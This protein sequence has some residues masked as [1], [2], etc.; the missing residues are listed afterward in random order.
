M[1]RTKWDRYKNR[2]NSDGSWKFASATSNGVVDFRSTGKHL[3]RARVNARKTSVG[4]RSQTGEHQKRK[5]GR[6]REVDRNNFRGE[7]PLNA[8]RGSS[9]KSIKDKSS[10]G[11]ARVTGESHS[12]DSLRLVSFGVVS[13]RVTSRLFASGSGR[14]NGRILR[15]VVSRRSTPFTSVT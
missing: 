14:G 4:G 10:E 13:S 5:G 3:L 11:S 8:R 12:L 9:R 15:P 1:T 6:E 2:E 7:H